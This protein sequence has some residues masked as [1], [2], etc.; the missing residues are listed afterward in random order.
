[1][2]N[3]NNNLAIV[4]CSPLKYYFGVVSGFSDDYTPTLTQR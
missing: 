4:F 1:M 2:F 3:N